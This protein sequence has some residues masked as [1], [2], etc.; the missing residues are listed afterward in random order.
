MPYYILDLEYNQYFDFHDNRQPEP[1]CPAEIIQMGVVVMDDKL[2]IKLR[3]ET[4]VRPQ[5]YKRLHPY[6]ERITGISKDDLRQAPA[7]P[8]AFEDFFGFAFGKRAVFCTWGNDDIK[9]LY[10]NILYYD[11]NHKRLTRRFLNVQKLYGSYNAAIHGEKA[12][13]GEAEQP[14]RQQIGLRNA[15]EGLGIPMERP[16]HTALSDAEYTAEVLARVLADKKAPSAALPQIL[17]VKSLQ[18]HIISRVN[19][20]N[21]RLLY[22]HAEHLLRRK[23][24]ERDKDALLELYILG[25]KGKFDVPRPR[26]P[27]ARN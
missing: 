8:D 21:I 12:E 10:R 25:R 14:S 17:D 22:N 5:I 11:L 23:L 20:V 24:S 26:H 9:E 6:V 19:S 1:A 3:R 13:N 7:F 15:I 2:N 4:L 18:D 27:R 16:F